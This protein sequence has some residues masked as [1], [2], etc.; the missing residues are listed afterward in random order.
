LLIFDIFKNLISIKNVLTPIWKCIGFVRGFRSKLDEFLNIS[1]SNVP[2][3]IFKI[4]GVLKIHEVLDPKS[5]V[6]V[7]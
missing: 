3:I 1:I 2:G 4:R 6:N 5:H 7:M